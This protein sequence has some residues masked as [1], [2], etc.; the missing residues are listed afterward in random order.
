MTKGDFEF[1]EEPHLNHFDNANQADVVGCLSN[2][3]G[4]SLPIITE[5]MVAIVS[6]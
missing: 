5:R 3:L 4:I 2:H 1:A 6:V